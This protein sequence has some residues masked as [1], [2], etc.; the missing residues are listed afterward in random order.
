PY[1]M[2]ISVGVL[3]FDAIAIAP[4]RLVAM[5]VIGGVLASLA[6]ALVWLERPQLAFFPISRLVL[7]SFLF[8]AALF[9]YCVAAGLSRTRSAIA[10]LTGAAVTGALLLVPGTRSTLVLL[11]SPL[12]M[13]V[14]ERT[15]RRIRVLLIAAAGLTGAVLL[16]WA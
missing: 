12:T 8:A 13:L 15:A 2:F 16:A 7:P 3:S 6:F 14:R 11:I 5:L 10:W 1:L 9:S 4:R